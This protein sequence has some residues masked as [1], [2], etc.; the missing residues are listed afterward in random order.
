LVA[1]EGYA[2]ETAIEKIENN[3]SDFN[4]LKVKD[5]DEYLYY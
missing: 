2:I 3:N 4:F 5:S 1:K